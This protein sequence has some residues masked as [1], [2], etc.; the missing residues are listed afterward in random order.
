MASESWSERGGEPKLTFSSLMRD[1]PLQV[2]TLFA[3][4]SL[5]NIYDTVLV[6]HRF[7]E[8]AV[9]LYRTL[10]GYVGIL[11]PMWVPFLV[12]E[13]V[14]PLALIVGALVRARFVARKYRRKV[15]IYGNTYGRA[16]ALV[17]GTIVALAAA[18]LSVVIATWQ[19][20]YIAI[21]EQKYADLLKEF[22]I[23]EAQGIMNEHAVPMAMEHELSEKLANFEMAALLTLLLLVCAISVGEMYLGRRTAAAVLHARARLFSVLLT[24]IYAAAILVL[25][26]RFLA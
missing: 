24:F 11:F 12:V 7:F 10:K 17:D 5:V 16:A 8:P 22:T 25:F 6:W 23:E 26:T 20:E 21:S 18:V 15:G 4:F 9:D 1:W 2:T 14:L 3:A 19:G 13:L